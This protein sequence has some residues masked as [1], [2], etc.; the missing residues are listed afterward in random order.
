MAQ[1]RGALPQL[2]GEL[3]LT[4]GGIETT[5]V[6]H[7]GIALPD[8][9]AFV[10]L[11][12]PDGQDA[13]RKY[14]RAYCAI[15]SHYGTGLILESPTWR[16]NP[17][18]ATHLGFTPQGLAEANRQA[19]ALLEALRSEVASGRTPVVIS[20]CVGPRGD[21]YIADEAMDE[22]QAQQYHSEQISVFAE[23]AADMVTAITMN[24]AEEA[25]GVALA[26]RE[27]RLPVA[28]SFTV[29]TDGRLPTGQTLKEAIE[30]V[31]S[32]TASYPSYYMVN[33]AHPD[34][35][36]DV[37]VPGSRWVQRIRGLR[38]NASRKSHAELNEATA[39]DSGDPEELG[40][41]YARLRQRLP[42]IN[43]MGGCCG[44]DHR[45]IEHIAK[46]CKPLFR[47]AL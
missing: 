29:E 41:Q 2:E 13:L 10:L 22:F 20:G 36:E 31:D 7:E 6:F 5:L 43:V 3:F 21:G 38:A 27:L 24:Y 39:L 44:T 28:I 15:A 25:L 42:H 4:D 45:H 18:W 12:Y 23:T 8:F 26:A 33:C 16:A 1:Y 34:H 11:N 19:I 35:F 40:A 46:A 17:D 47:A 30:Q 9:A 32:A 37:L 14:F